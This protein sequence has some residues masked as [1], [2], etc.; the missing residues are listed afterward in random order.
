[1][2]A[3]NGTAGLT[4]GAV[5]VFVRDGTGWRQ[6]GVVRATNPGGGDYFGLRLALATDRLLV[7]ASRQSVQNPMSMGSSLE[8]AGSAYVFERDSGVW[9]QTVQLTA[10]PPVAQQQFGYSVAL[11]GQTLAIAALGDSSSS[12]G[13]IMIFE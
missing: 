11:A 10:A 1:M 13:A 12:S 3:F 2:G 6:E 7:G 5:F 4:S 9:R 8:S